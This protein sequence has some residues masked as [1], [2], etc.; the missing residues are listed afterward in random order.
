M[1][2]A[3]LVGFCACFSVWINRQALNSDN[4]TT[5]SSRILADGRVQSALSIYLVNELYSSVDVPGTIQSALPSQLQG[6]AGPLAAGVRQLAN[7]AV[8]TLLASAPVQQAWR[9]ANQTAFNELLQILNGNNRVLSTSGGEV[10]LNLHELVTDLATQLGVGDKVAAARTKLAGG[11]GLAARGAVEEKLGVTL[12]AN[13]GRLV[14]MR[15]KQL[16]TAQDIAKAIRGLAVVLP[17]LTLALFALAIWLA[18]GWRRIALRT[19]GACLFGVGVALLLARRVA[20][21]GIVNG[22]VA[23]P[24]NRPA[25]Q[26]AWS[27]GTSLLYDLAVAVIAYGLVLIAAAWLAGGTHAA[28]FLR[29]LTAPALRMHPTGSYAMAGLILLL[30]VAWG[31]TPA[32]RQLL[33]VLGLAALAALGVTVLRR[34][35]EVEFPDALPADTWAELRRLRHFGHDRGA[36]GPTASVGADESAVASGATTTSQ[37]AAAVPNGPAAAVEAPAAGEARA[38]D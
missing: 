1:A 11:A 28:T 19:T 23:D 33:P 12:P 16:K 25:A 2:V 3:T 18:Q 6:L 14:I 32:T 36:P 8:P 5:T 10:A 4:W 22:L 27:I 37:P 13:T 17:L 38:P 30:I 31:P 21:E 35:T 29:R 26:A 9:K 24:T 15:S 7:Q 20:G 34:Q